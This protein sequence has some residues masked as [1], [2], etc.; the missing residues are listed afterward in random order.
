MKRYIALFALILFAIQFSVSYADSRQSHEKLELMAE[1]LE[2]REIEL[3]EWSLY[4]RGNLGLIEDFNG[5]LDTVEKLKSKMP[6]L[7]WSTK[8]LKSGG[9]WKMS[10]M[11]SHGDGSVERLTVIAYPHKK[12]LASY[13]IYA[14]EGTHLPESGF[15]KTEKRFYEKAAKFSS[16]KLNYFSCMSGITGDKMKFGLYNEAHELVSSFSAV[17]IEELQEETFVS[18]SAYTALWDDAITTAQDKMNLQIAVRT[19]GLGGRTTVTIGT[20][21]ITSEY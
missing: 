20:P 8:P 5:Y 3:T 1:Q 10:G 2:K 9:E 12:E 16:E 7:D 21:I 15:K 13:F 11:K 19:D 4:T 17:P 14:V 6:E 18:L